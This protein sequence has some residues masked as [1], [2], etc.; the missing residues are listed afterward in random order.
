MNTK[1]IL[2]AVAALALQGCAALPMNW[3]PTDPGSRAAEGVWEVIDTVDTVQTARFVQTDCHEADPAARFIYGGS[4]P[5]PARVVA[6]NLVL[7]SVHSYVSAY[8]DRKVDHEIATDNADGNEGLWYTGRIVWHAV[9]IA[10]STASV[11]NNRSL[12]CHK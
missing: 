11:I 5:A 3:Q 8:L 2:A 12:K 1:L 4:N 7:M 10:A 6:T 9:S